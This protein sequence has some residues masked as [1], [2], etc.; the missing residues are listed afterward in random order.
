MINFIYVCGCFACMCVGPPHSCLL[1]SEA[2]RRPSGP[3]DWSYRWLLA[4]MWAL[5][6][7][8]EQLPVLLAL[9]PFFQAGFCGLQ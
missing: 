6:S 2:K 1:T 7:N 9:G 3:W 5:E 4:T 8:L